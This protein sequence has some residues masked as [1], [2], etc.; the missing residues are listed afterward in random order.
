M[1]RRLLHQLVLI[2]MFYRQ[3]AIKV[4]KKVKANQVKIRVQLNIARIF[5]RKIRKIRQILS[6]LPIRSRNLITLMLKNLKAI[7]KNR[8]LL[9]EQVIHF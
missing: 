2:R 7:R 8:R 3:R 1:S 4:M 5:I 6:Y 9:N